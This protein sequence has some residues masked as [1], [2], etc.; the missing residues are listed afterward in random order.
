MLKDTSKTAYFIHWHIRKFLKMSSLSA[1]VSYLHEGNN[2]PMIHERV[3][4]L[5]N[6][7][8]NALIPNA[9]GIHMMTRTVTRFILRIRIVTRMVKRLDTIFRPGMEHKFDSVTYSHLYTVTTIQISNIVLIMFS[10]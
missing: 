8:H 9:V 10:A 2:I 1:P 5:V 7:I 4:L 6:S 3:S